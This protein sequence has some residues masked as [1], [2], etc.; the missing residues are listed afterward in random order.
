ML[1]A[2]NAWAAPQNEKFGTMFREFAEAGF[3]G[4]E[5]NLE[6]QPSAHSLTLETSDQELREI[7]QL[8]EQNGLVI[9]S[10]CAACLGNDLG[11]ADPKENQR[12]LNTV[13]RQLEMA[14][15][16]GCRS[17]LVYPGGFTPDTSLAFAYKRALELFWELKPE[18]QRQP[19]LVSIENANQFFLSP[20][21][22]AKF[23][24][25]IHSPMVGAYLDFANVQIFQYP[26]SHHWLEVLGKRVFNVHIKDYKPFGLGMGAFV[27]LLA[28]AVP[29]PK[30]MPM[31]RELGYEGPLVAELPNMMPSAPRHLY[32]TT[33]MALDE[34][35][36]F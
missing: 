15:I 22:F 21:D 23:L 13:R 16:L 12:G 33:V 26:Y 20:F 2:M 14:N 31:L 18:I 4:V 32:R 19:V 11:S 9:T 7:R 3:S 25:D 34:I 10:I 35:Q 28:G 6:A 17:I 30:I 8:A 29:Y 36:Q 1:K 24:D 5:L 27:P